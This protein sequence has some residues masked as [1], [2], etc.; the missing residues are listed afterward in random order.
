MRKLILKIIFKIFGKK[1]IIK[2]LDVNLISKEIGK[3]NISNCINQ[4]IL[5]A[6]SLFYEEAEINNIPKD[7]SKITIGKNTHIRGKLL[8]FNYGGE[9]KIGDDCYIGAGTRI[10]SGKSVIIGNNVLI[11]HDVNIVDTNSHEINHIERAN[12]YKELVINGHWDSQGSIETE[13]I[14][15][16]DDAWIS[17]G[18]SILKGVS[19]GKGSIIAA[20]SV[21]TKDVSDWTMV[22]GNPAKPIKNL[23]NA[24]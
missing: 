18:A 6:G 5:G 22:A 15:I 23:H 3:L 9:I 10:W 2:A 16:K 19:V 11:S 13:P 21:V 4:V 14:V 1:N 17:F 8:I 20:N 24:E 12:R 7:K